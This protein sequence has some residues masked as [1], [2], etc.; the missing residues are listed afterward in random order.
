M[1]PLAV[2]DLSS[3][4]VLAC[5][6]YCDDKRFCHCMLPFILQYLLPLLSSVFAKIGIYI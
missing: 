5:A 2:S 4:F 6:V 3:G 1:T